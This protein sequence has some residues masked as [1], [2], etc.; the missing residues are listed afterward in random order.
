MN[1]ETP[2]LISVFIARDPMERLL[3][4]DGKLSPLYGDV[5][6]RRLAELRT[7]EQW[8]QAKDA[9]QMD[10]FALHVLAK[11]CED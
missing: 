11:N 7:P 4:K 5:P 1:W 9:W 8:W 2:W 6:K 3:A 10:N